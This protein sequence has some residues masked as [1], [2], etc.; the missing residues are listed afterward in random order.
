[1]NAAARRAWSRARALALC[2]ALTA[3]TLAACARSREPGPSAQPTPSPA[4]ATAPLDEVSADRAR[5]TAVI[6][7]YYAA[8]DARRYRDAYALWAS[9]GAAS[10]QS[11]EAFSAGFARTDSVAVRL[12]TPGAIE[13]A[14]GSRYLDVPV[15]IVAVQSDGTRQRF[16]GTYTLRRTVV[17]GATPEQRSWRIQSARI[18]RSQP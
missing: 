13:G 14:A 4:D 17:D 1:M 9:G 8:I 5:A 12:G 11:L 6:H 15:D 2:A 7:D 3:L 16:A 18:T 10:G